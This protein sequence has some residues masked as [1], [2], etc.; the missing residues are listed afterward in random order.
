VRGRLA[1]VLVPGLLLVVALAACGKKGNPLPPLRPVPARIADFAASRTQG[2]VELRFTVPAA[3]LD[4]TVPV[5]IDRIDI[6]GLRAAE[7]QAPPPA[8]QLSGDPRNLIES[9]PVR[10]PVTAAGEAEATVVSTLVPQPGDVAVYVDRTDAA[11][12][13]GVAAM[14]YVAVP[15]V[16]TGR[17]RRGPPSPVAQVPLGALPAPP[18]NVALS[19]DETSVRA[20]WTPAAPGQAFRV[21]RLPRDAG[22]SREVLTPEP[23]TAGE[24]VVPTEFDR[25]LCV[26]IQAVQVTGP[27]SIEGAL[28][29]RVCITP[30]DRYPPPVPGDLRVVQEGTAVTLIWEAV[31]AADLAGYI[32]LRGEGTTATLVPLLRSP[33]RETTYRDTTAAAGTT[34]TYAVYA[35]D[36]SRAAN[37]SALSNRETITVR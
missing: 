26:A 35:V 4:G 31:E 22:Q 13:A 21:V 3:N 15:V 5:A 34:Y 23:V 7:G 10:R 14:Y 37:V 28:S 20:T 24:F 16:G 33:I 30:A 11:E 25:E 18:T 36:S 29:E 1:H 12:Q 17:G 6:Y 2:Q 27:V 9:L 32:V 19:H 8:G